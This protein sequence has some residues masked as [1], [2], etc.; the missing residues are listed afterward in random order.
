MNITL[1]LAGGSGRR[2]EQ[3]IPKQFLEINGKPVIAYTMERFEKHPD[4]DGMIVVCIAGWQE[5]LKQIIREYHITKVIDVIEGGAN[6]QES[7]CRG[8]KYLEARYPKDALVLVHD[9]IRPMVSQKII[10]DAIAVCR[11][12]GSAIAMIPCVEAMLYSENQTS[13]GR[14]YKREY[15]KR[16]Q[17]PQ[18]LPLGDLAELHRQAGERGITD[19]TATCT[20]MIE[21]GHE[22]YFCAGSE[23]NIKLT[24]QDDLM[25][26]RAL[27]LLEKESGLGHA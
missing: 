27:L 14:V 24:T 13:S 10:S 22:V 19:S 16:T 17:T 12:R 11:C 18:A 6:G 15:L 7:I 20:L 4:I 23:Q 3:N 2:M 5:H 1:L 9:A 26:F 8:V 25:I 21:L